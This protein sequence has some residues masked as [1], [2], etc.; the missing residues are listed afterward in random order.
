MP[1][2]LPLDYAS[3][4]HGRKTA[5]PQGAITPWLD[6]L[7][8][9]YLKTARCF[10][11]L[12]VEVRHE[13]P[14]LILELIP[15]ITRQSRPHAPQI[16]CYTPGE[17]LWLFTILSEPGFSRLDSDPLHSR[18]EIADDEFKILLFL[19]WKNVPCHDQFDCHEDTFTFVLD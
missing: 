1:P 4:Q 12:K 7:V 6:I 5:V 19:A 8:I 16:I 10:D 13:L 14:Q 17:D 18:H 9:L 3:W 15:L 2:D 11:H